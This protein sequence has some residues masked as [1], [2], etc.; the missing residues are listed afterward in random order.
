MFKVYGLNQVG[1]FRKK[2][3]TIEAKVLYVDRLLTASLCP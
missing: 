3:M 1:Y 2:K